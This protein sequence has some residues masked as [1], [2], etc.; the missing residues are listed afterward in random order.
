MKLTLE[1]NLAIG[2][3]LYFLVA[4][5]KNVYAPCRVCEN[6]REVTIKVKDEAYEIS[7]PECSHKKIKGD[8]ANRI[9][10]FQYSVYNTVIKGF[11]YE[12][13]AYNVKGEQW[14]IQTTGFHKINLETLT[15]VLRDKTQFFTDV[16][17]ADNMAKDLNKK[18]KLKQ[19]AFLK[20]VGHDEGIDGLVM[21]LDVEF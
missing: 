1:T 3:Q 11:C 5:E 16:E 9:K 18:E 17:T 2:Q 15:S 12:N 13:P 21:P 20:G 19:K 4:K 8:T 6:K 14:Y 7:C 10:I